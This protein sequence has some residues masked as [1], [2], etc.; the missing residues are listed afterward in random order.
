VNLPKNDDAVFGGPGGHDDGDVWLCDGGWQCRYQLW[1]VD[2]SS[3]MLM[4]V[5][6]LIFSLVYFDGR[7]KKGAEKAIKI[8]EGKRQLGPRAF[9]PY[10]EL[11]F[12][13]F[14]VV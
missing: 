5:E 14:T 12:T 7:K 10:L 9:L 4:V 6:E 1:V 8:R 2:V 3:R 11:N 13:V